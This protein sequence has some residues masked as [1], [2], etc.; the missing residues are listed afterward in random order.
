[1]GKLKGQLEYKKFQ[2]GKPLSPKQSIVAHCFS[3]N[4]EEDGSNEDCQG[5]NCPLYPYFRKWLL[6]GRKAIL[7]AEKPTSALH[8]T[9]GI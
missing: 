7:E 3:C 4:G 8:Q 1:M 5:K 9:K 2:E 6:K